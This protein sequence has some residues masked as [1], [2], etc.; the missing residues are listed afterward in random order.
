[1]ALQASKKISKSKAGGDSGHMVVCRLNVTL[2]QPYWHQELA[3]RHPETSIEVLGY[4]L[5]K[6]GMLL[7]LRVH[8]NDIA[9]WVDELREFDDIYD[10]TPLG[11]VGKAETVRV[12]YKENA[13]TATANRLHLILRTPVTVKDGAYEVVMAGPEKN[14]KQFI[15]MFPSKVRLMAV[16]DAERNGGTTLTPRQSYVFHR[17]MEAGYFEV[18]R[19]VTLT[20]LAA[21]IGVAVSSL[22]EMLAIVEKKLLEESLVAKEQ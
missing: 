21:Q 9:S 1:M 12:T 15:R 5:T 16:Y 3:R 10:V 18:P 11:R 8:V 20:Q 7:D 19:R 6:D 2:S 4:S 17:A 22:S 13:F 14:V